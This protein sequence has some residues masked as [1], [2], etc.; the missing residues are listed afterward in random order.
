M[1]REE[2]IKN[3]KKWVVLDRQIKRMNKSSAHEL[4]N[5]GSQ[6]IYVI[7]WRIIRYKIKESKSVMAI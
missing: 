5:V 2:F 1:S 7:I 3:I 6:M 4:R